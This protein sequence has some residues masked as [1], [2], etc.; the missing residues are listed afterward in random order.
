VPVALD[1]GQTVSN[2]LLS[3][4]FQSYHL[5]F[6]SPGPDFDFSYFFNPQIT[7]AIVESC[8]QQLDVLSLFFCK[9]QL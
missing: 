9:V 5:I 7:D 8:S 1:G 4:F 6:A 3:Y 2:H